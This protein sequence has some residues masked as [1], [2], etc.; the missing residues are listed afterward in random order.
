MQGVAA[1][2]DS[3]ATASQSAPKTTAPDSASG[4]P[5]IGLPPLKWTHGFELLRVRAL[6]HS[7]LQQASSHVSKLKT[8]SYRKPLLS[9][10]RMQISRK[11][12]CW[13]KE[14]MVRCV[15]STLKLVTAQDPE[16]CFPLREEPCTPLKKASADIRRRFLKEPALP[17]PKLMHHFEVTAAHGIP[18]R[19]SKAPAPTEAPPAVPNPGSRQSVGVLVWDCGWGWLKPRAASNKGIS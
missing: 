17:F 7:E 4:P 5:A 13:V 10:V 15:P 14:A 2:Y 8:C 12:E 11:P 19:E 1:P 18:P 6:S 16:L 3:V 9:P